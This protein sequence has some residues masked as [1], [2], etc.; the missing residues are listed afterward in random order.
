MPGDDNNAERAN[1]EVET[2]EE[3]ERKKN[4]RGQG[5]EGRGGKV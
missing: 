5:G 4:N 3:I 2:F 1:F